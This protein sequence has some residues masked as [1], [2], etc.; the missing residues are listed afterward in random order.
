MVKRA[1]PSAV[2]GSPAI[3]SQPTD[4][5]GRGYLR[6]PSHVCRNAL[7][8]RRGSPRGRDFCGDYL[9]VTA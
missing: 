8:G 6:G 3:R 2:A 9:E 1:G 7:M 5:S 4:Q